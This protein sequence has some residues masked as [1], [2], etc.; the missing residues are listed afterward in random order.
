MKLTGDKIQK[1]IEAELKEKYGNLDEIDWGA[2][3]K[4]AADIFTPTSVKASRAIA[5]GEYE[6]E[7]KTVT[8]MIKKFRTLKSADFSGVAPNELPI[9]SKMFDELLSYAKEG[10]LTS[11]R[12]NA[13]TNI[14]SKLVGKTV[15]AAEPEAA[16][17]GGAPVDQ[18]LQNDIMDALNL[19]SDPTALGEPTPNKI[20]RIQTDLIADLKNAGVLVQGKHVSEG[21]DYTKVFYTLINTLNERKIISLTEDLTKFVRK[22]MIKELL[23]EV[24]PRASAGI[25]GKAR[26]R[27]GPR[28]EVPSAAP[29]PGRSE[30]SD[31]IADKIY[32]LVK[33]LGAVREPTELAQISAGLFDLLQKGRWIASNAQMKKPQELGALAGADKAA[34][35]QTVVDLDAG[36]TTVD[37]TKLK[38]Q[39][40]GEWAAEKAGE[41]AAA[42]KGQDQKSY[43]PETAERERREKE[44]KLT[45]KQRAWRTQ[46]GPLPTNPAQLA[47]IGE[48]MFR[49]LHQLGE[50]KVFRFNNKQKRT[51]RTMMLAET[52]I[53]VQKRLLTCL[54]G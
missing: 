40:T 23:T 10:N 52:Q 53:A 8:D 34:V 4:R 12:I 35:D 20:R 26:Q 43:D 18:A 47:A 27:R 19:L 31:E 6:D 49:L 36:D 13:L 39:D 41:L 54:R 29:K 50:Q 24:F 25:L 33:K 9:I 45:P 3:M 14:I 15:D 22:S 2:Q 32:G 51:I 37:K 46:M 16:A 1:L 28:A 21:I 48:G 5:S 42:A 44:K 30:D 11:G 38:K 7:P 17:E